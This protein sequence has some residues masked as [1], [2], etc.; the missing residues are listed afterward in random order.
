MKTV[1]AAGGAALALLGAS[2]AS[3]QSR[4]PSVSLPYTQGPVWTY[5]YIDVKPGQFEA[6]M[7]Y[8]SGNW[9]RA[10]EAAKKSGDLMD[11]KVLVV[12]SPRAG[13]PDIILASQWKNMAVFDR[14]LE[15]VQAESLAATSQTQQ[16]ATRGQ[17]DREAMR[18]NIGEM[19]VR[20]LRFK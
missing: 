3:T 5:S 11:Y 15:E 2:A 7:T 4:G 20:E 14:S 10:Q 13:E 17:M 8:L 9:R 18:S 12:D 1:I 6:Y 19:M 16:Q